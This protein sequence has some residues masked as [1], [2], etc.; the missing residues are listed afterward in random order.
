MKHSFP[1]ASPF[2]ELIQ[3][4][5]QTPERII[6]RD[7]SAS[8]TA[9]AG[10]LLQAVSH[11]REKV[12]ESIVRN[13]INGDHDENKEKF[14]FLLAPPGFE[15]VVS[16]LT[17]LSLGA[18]MSAQSI[19][20]RPEEIIRL[21]K[22]ARPL[23]LLFAPALAD[24]VKATK[25][26]YAEHGNGVDL[27]P[28]IEI[29]ATSSEKMGSCTYSTDP[30]SDSYLSQT[31]SLFFTSGTSG[32]QKGVVHSYRALLA[33]ARE[34]IESW[35]LTDK[36]VVLNQKPGNWMGGIFGIIPSLISGACL[37]TC[38]GVFDPKWFWERI[39][40][41]GVSI[42]DVAP[43]G[44]DRLAQYFD[45]HIAALPEA[46]K[47][48]YIQGMIQ[49]KVAGTSGSLLPPHTQKRWTEL[50]RGKPLLNLY[51]S[52][53]VT[54]I[55]SMRWQNP[56][57]SDMCSVGPP[58]PGVEVKL[59]DG[60]VRLKAPSMFSRYI[61]DDPTQTEKAFDSDG[62]FKTGDCAEKIGDC[63]KLYGRA[64]IDV[65]HFWGFTLHTGEIE[66][67]LFTL[68]YI[69]NA[70][71]FPVEDENHEERAAAI[72]QIHPTSQSKP[73]DLAT[74]RSDLTASTGLMLLKQPTVVYWLRG[75]EEISLTAN[76]KISKVD[77]RK[78]FFGDKWWANE[79]LEILDLKTIEYWRMGGQC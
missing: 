59:V 74:L 31:G 16:M 60:E 65:L 28:F 17:I 34:R 32:N 57:Y 19:V 23:A 66:T 21:L 33:S 76:G 15:Y 27:P 63:Y 55:C 41:G 78:R 52:T 62:F 48:K 11:F 26:L 3:R 70:V 61:S 36:D 71:V 9:T 25:D 37:E 75:E 1:P 73:P 12:D 54:L 39:S 42:F 40:Q 20:I 51:G 53:E 4:A 43:T 77:A 38:A 8:V 56:E 79:K 68:P 22:L 44:Y 46:E 10:Q 45:D 50:R 69:A 67:A 30:N 72:L 18:G 13:A 64:N 5:E 29:Q 35:D 24:K 58:V 2:P 49:A 6:L 14:I 7:H 47:E